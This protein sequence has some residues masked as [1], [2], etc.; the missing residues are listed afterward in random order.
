MFDFKKFYDWIADI[1]PDGARLCEVG[2]ADG[3]SAIYL[4]NAMLNRGKDV[5]VY[6]VDNMDYGQ[7]NQ[8]VT[9]YTNIIKGKV[10]LF[11]EVIPKES[12]EAAKDFND[13]FL[14]FVY[15]DASHQYEQ[16]KN[17]IK[18]WYP[19]VKDEGYIAGHDYF[20]YEGVK[21]AVDELMP[22]TIQ[23]EDLY[24]EDGVLQQTFEPEQFLH[25]EQTDRGYGLFWAQK[26]FYKH[27]SV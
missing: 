12:I 22:T 23:R 18:A 16:T 3:E 5:L 15:I 20:L 7:Y 27:L 8:I 25:V 21:K 17:D 14:D 11:T 24:D 4:A 10:G 13:G 2:V 1:M 26:D 6:M 9:I 19:K